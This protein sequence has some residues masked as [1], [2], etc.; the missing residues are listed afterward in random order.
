[1]HSFLCKIKKKERVEHIKMTAIKKKARRGMENLVRVSKGH[2]VPLYLNLPLWFHKDVRKYMFSFLT[3]GFY[4]NYDYVVCFAS[5]SEKT[6]QIGV[7]DLQYYCRQGY[8]R[9]L[10]FMIQ[11]RLCAYLPTWVDVYDM[12]DSAVTNNH[13]AILQILYDNFV[14][15]SPLKNPCGYPCKLILKAQA[16]GHQEIFEWLKE[17]KIGKGHVAPL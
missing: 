15:W 8:T 1:L 17:R 2:I 7:S 13:L 14:L 11:N 6:F 4:N 9:S 12:Y 5:H 3:K 10:L 16:L